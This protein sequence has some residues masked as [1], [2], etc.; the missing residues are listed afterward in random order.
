MGSEHLWELCPST[1]FCCEPKSALRSRVYERGR[2][3]NP[4]IH[5]VS[6]DRVQVLGLRA[7]LSARSS[8]QDGPVHSRSGHPLPCLPWSLPSKWVVPAPTRRSPCPHRLLGLCSGFC[9]EAWVA[10]GSLPTTKVC[11]VD[12]QRPSHPIRSG[13]AS[14]PPLVSMGLQARLPP[15]PPAQGFPQVGEGGLCHRG[16]RPPPHLAPAGTLGQPTA[17]GSLGFFSRVYQNSP[18]TRRVRSVGPHN[19]KGLC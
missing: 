7:L 19:G 16:K 18:A 15:P 4:E 17:P 3:G 5:R 1:Q 11:S 13:S 14:P 10:A 6:S 12:R 8:C 9:R 2:K